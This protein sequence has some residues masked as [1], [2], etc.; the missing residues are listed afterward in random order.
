MAYRILLM[1]SAANGVT[2]R[3][4]LA[5]RRAGREVAVEVVS[6]AD[7]MDAAVA[8]H[9]FDAIICPYLVS[10]IPARITHRWPTVII[11][12]GVVGDRGPSSLD[13]ARTEREKLW[14]TTAMM[15][16]EEMDAGPVVATNTYA[17]PEDTKSAIYNTVGADA[18]IACI[19]Q[20]ADRLQDR[21]FTPV[22]QDEHPRILAHARTRPAIR[23]NQRAIDWTKAAKDILPGIHAADGS[24]GALTTLAGHSVHIYDAHLSAVT[25][26]GALPGTIIGSTH[27]YLQIAC[28]SGSLLIGHLRARDETVPPVK[29]PAVDV[30]KRLG[31]SDIPAVDVDPGWTD[32]RYHRDGDAVGTVEFFAYNGAFSVD[33]SLRL[34]AAIRH[35]AAQPTR[36]LVIRGTG[37]YFSNGLHLG[38]IELAQNP[39]AEG[40]ASI[41]AINRVCAEIAECEQVTI[42]AVQGSAGA[43]G[44]MLALTADFVVAAERCV[45]NPHYKLMGLTGSELHTANLPRRVGRAKAEELLATAEP[46]DTYGAL[47]IGLIDEIRPNRSFPQS[48]HRF[49]RLYTGDQLYRAA[50][51]NKEE[52]RRTT[53]KPVEVILAE[54]TSRMHNCFF[55]DALGHREKRQAFIRKA[56]TPAQVSANHMPLAG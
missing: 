45:L 4:A 47:E 5:L 51:Y 44:V 31:V 25:A 7:D 14:G 6:N 20:T 49:A 19:L 34:A 30:L 8:R 1:S 17:M 24:P 32:I 54:E 11:H 23:Q 22:P 43:G 15:A 42:A 26:P 18:A 28:G 52:R 33:F 35:A 10:K 48:V 39:D 3:A 12:P 9:D 41:N 56:L 38:S 13:Y 2:Q 46:I 21:N 37:P 53:K 29:A 27:H 50:L 40:W 36:V 55:Q 16:V